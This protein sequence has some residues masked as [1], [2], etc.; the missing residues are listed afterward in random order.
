MMPLP[1]CL[2]RREYD[3]GAVLAAYPPILEHA[4]KRLVFDLA[5]PPGTKHRGPIELTRWAAAALP[6]TVE[7]GRTEVVAKPGY[8]D[9][10]GS[11]DGVWHV[12]FADPELFVAYGSSLLAQ[13][14]LQA[15]EHPLLGSLREALIAEDQLPLTEDNDAPT[16]V[17]ILG[18]ERRC[19]IDTAPDRDAG[20]PNGLYG[21]RFAVAPAKTVR[22]A[23][24]VLDPATRS[25]LISIAAPV[26]SGSYTRAQI[27]K[28]VVTAYSGF[29]A[30]VLESHRAWP[31]APV[32]VR[33][34]FWGCGAFGGN[35]HA[36]TLL[37][38][39]AAQLAGVDRLVF[40]ASDDTGVAAFS[41]GAAQ[42]AQVIAA[43]VPGEPLADLLQRVAALD[44]QWGTSD[45][46]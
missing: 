17:L 1:V 45:G 22:A 23:V 42:L 4:H 18:A 40:Y 28:I 39:L 34:G 37:Q 38:V 31:A 30:A 8:Y 5:C 3:P 12:N 20:R 9:Y 14:E 35:R 11:G 43:G 7:L 26:G 13:D 24:R 19:A 15:A 25:H 6:Q 27:A 10:E 2:L 32:E 33:T 44:Y 36:M 21:N 29:A 46:N 41:T 16:P